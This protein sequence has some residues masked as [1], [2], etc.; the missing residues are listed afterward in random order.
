M[1]VILRL[2]C[3]SS[4]ML[5]QRSKG[6]LSDSPGS[7][8]DLIGLDADRETAQE[9]T[10]SS[11]RLKPWA[12]NLTAL[13]LGTLL[14]FTV[15][16]VFLRV[17][18]NVGLTAS[19]RR[20]L[21]WRKSHRTS[22]DLMRR[23][24][25]SY[26]RYSPEVGW[27]LKPDLRTPRL[28]SNSRGLRGSREYALTPA[29][30][31]TRILCLGDSFILGENLPDDETLPVEL[32]SILNRQGRWEVINLGEHGYG[33]DQ[34]LLRLRQIGFQYSAKIIVLGFFE[35]DLGRNTMSF[36]D[37][38]KPYFE[39]S[40]DDLILHNTPVP[41]PSEILARPHL[42]PECSLRSLCAIEWLVQR[43]ARVTPW[44][45]LEYT[46]PGKVT[47]GIL[48]TI[49][50]ESRSHGMKFVLMTIPPQRFK[51]TPSKVESLLTNWA[52][53]T[54]TPMVNLREAFLKL[55]KEDRA[56]LYHGHWTAYGA[57]LSAKIL[58]QKITELTV[59]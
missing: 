41:S 1:A 11:R 22:E 46:A 27:E 43:I 48:D 59:M 28:T 35:D 10:N 57:A 56:R 39:I 44:V 15:A 18:P 55:P 2:K 16:E 45:P 3:A 49:L 52:G 25:Y 13:V 17:F 20:E 12:A 26:D 47:L 42:L 9:E 29:P 31:V 53:R 36:R 58:A 24:V 37:Y 5:M 32:E 54:E 34:Q 21:T 6:R 7:S 14:S 38:A 30:G 51:P 50:Q 4:A 40:G 23:E 33:T 8:P 19:E